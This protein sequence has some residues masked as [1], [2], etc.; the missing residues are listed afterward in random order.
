MY[1]PLEMCLEMTVPF[2]VT[3]I[4]R[5]VSALSEAVSVYAFDAIGLS[6]ETLRLNWIM[7][8]ASRFLSMP[9]SLEM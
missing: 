3:S 8:S 6:V 7:S 2:E 5:S 4:Y 1:V 9:P